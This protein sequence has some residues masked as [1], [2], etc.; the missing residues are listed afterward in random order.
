[1]DK[2]ENTK[3]R[4]FIGLILILAGITYYL[5]EFVYAFFVEITQTVDVT[6]ILAI[7]PILIGVY[8]MYKFFTTRNGLIFPV[9]VF[10]FYY[11]II[12]MFFTSPECYGL[13]LTSMLFIVPSATLLVFYYYDK[14]PIYLLIGIFLLVVGLGIVLSCFVDI[15]ILNDNVFYWGLAFIV[16][17]LIKKPIS[18]PMLILGGII[19]VFSLKG[20]LEIEGVANIIISVALVIAGIYVLARTFI[21]KK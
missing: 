14:I 15:P 13:M 4:V 9:G 12:Q 20:L 2:K 16:T 19:T 7:V 10:L 21:N 17:A 18:K 3:L 5:K 11:G 8:C 6:K 1:M